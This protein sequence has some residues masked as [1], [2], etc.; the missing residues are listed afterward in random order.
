MKEY[1]FTCKMFVT[2]SY[3]GSV[4]CRDAQETLDMYIDRWKTND[5]FGTYGAPLDIKEITL[6]KENIKSGRHDGYA[7]GNLYEIKGVAAYNQDFKVPKHSVRFRIYHTVRNDY[8][9]AWPILW[10]SIKIH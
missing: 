3:K 10:N 6:L 1:N 4:M 7:T 9:C 5:S 8:Y 2:L